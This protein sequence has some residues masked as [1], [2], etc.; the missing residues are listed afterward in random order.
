MSTSRNQVSWE[1]M[2]KYNGI[3][4][5]WHNDTGDIL[6]VLCGELE[7][8][9]PV[10][11]K[12]DSFYCP[13]FYSYRTFSFTHYCLVVGT[14]MH[15]QSFLCLDSYVNN[16]IQYLGYSDF[17]DGIKQYAVV[18]CKHS[19][20]KRVDI[21]EIIEYVLKTLYEKADP[22]EQ[23]ELFSE[24]YMK[25][26][27]LK[28]EKRGFTDLQSIPLLRR[29]KEIENCRVNFSEFLVYLSGKACNGMYLHDL[30]DGFRKAAGLWNNIRMI[31]L[32]MMIT[33]KEYVKREL[34]TGKVQEIKNIETGIREKMERLVENTQNHPDMI[35]ADNM[36]G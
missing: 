26:F 1:L 36:L 9:R 6:E 8:S 33:N 35:S 29:L 27:D 3:Q 12:I 21:A 15:L 24:Y 4:F 2:E 30:A 25:D 7:N 32:K 23:M 17:I 22:F 20:F 10:V 11:L 28:R 13:W 14:D 34:V 16:S 31:I 18:K 19:N 5:E